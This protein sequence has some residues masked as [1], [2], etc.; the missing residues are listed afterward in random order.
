MQRSACIPYRAAVPALL[1]K[2]TSGPYVPSH[3]ISHTTGEYFS[4]EGGKHLGETLRS[5]QFPRYDR[6]GVLF[7]LEARTSSFSLQNW[8]EIVGNR[9]L[10]CQIHTEAGGP[11]SRLQPLEPCPG[12]AEFVELDPEAIH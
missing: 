6:T 9:H 1:Q 10:D 5:V 11:R 7:A 12:V 8:N 4:S 3:V 2:G